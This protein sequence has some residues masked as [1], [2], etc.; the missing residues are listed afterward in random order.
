MNHYY[1]KNWEPLEDT[2]RI[3]WDLAGGCLSFYTAA[4]IFSKD[5]VDSGTRWLVKHMTREEPCASF[6]DLGCGYGAVGIALSRLG[7]CHDAYYC[8]V[9]FKALR[10][11]RKNL[12]VNRVKGRIHCGEGADALRDHVFDGV[13]LNP[14]IRAGL[15]AV[16]CLI[17]GGLRTLKPK[18]RFYLVMRTRQG[19][20]R[21]KKDP[22]WAGLSFLEIGRDGGYR[23]FRMEAP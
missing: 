5:R 18:G 3:Q 20:L 12:R 21:L 4:G 13:A 15:D 7:W 6:L 19:A 14:P 10:L 9:N 2:K 16:L 11:A 17:R 22:T 1:C 23:V 8:D